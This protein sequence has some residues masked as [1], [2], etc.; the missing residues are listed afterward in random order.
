MNAE[1]MRGS[2]CW[3][4]ASANVLLSGV[5]LIFC[6]ATSPTYSA[7]CAI[8]GRTSGPGRFVDILDIAVGPA[9]RLF[10]VAAIVMNG[11]GTAVGVRV[12]IGQE[13]VLH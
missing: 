8:G 11:P 7:V 2:A 9:S 6:Y 3:P 5:V 12:G 10:E 1:L 13:E 4:H